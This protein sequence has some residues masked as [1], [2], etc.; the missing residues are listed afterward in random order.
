MTLKDDDDSIKRSLGR[1]N[2]KKN[3]GAGLIFFLPVSTRVEM[4]AAVVCVW[5]VSKQDV[6]SV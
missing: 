5:V 3:I 4:L 6:E 2:V 1:R